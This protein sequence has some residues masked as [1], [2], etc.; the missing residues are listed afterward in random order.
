MSAHD[1]GRSS[2]RALDGKVALITGASSGIGAA[3]ARVFAAEGASVVLGARSAVRLETVAADIAAHGGR[4]L[5]VL[6]DAADERFAKQLV[7]AALARFGGLD[8]AVGNAGV[9][10]DLAAVPDMAPENWRRVLAVN[11][12]GAFLTARAALPALLA[13]GGGSLLFTSSF[14]GHTAGIPG[15]AAYA[16]SKAGLLGLVQVLAAEY[17]PRNLRVNALL[18]GGTD[19]PM[20]RG[21][22]PTPE[23][24]R[25][26]A[27]LHALKRIAAPEEIARAALFLCSDAASFVTGSAFLADGGVSIVRG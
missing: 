27:N 23:A 6:G 19:T 7:A 2:M 24:Q 8:I 26:V 18:P 16:A 11:L 3:M 10:G 12:D 20:G 1:N 17:G 15:M 21:F 25:S 5:A 22:A 4:A 14:V 13:R 9:V